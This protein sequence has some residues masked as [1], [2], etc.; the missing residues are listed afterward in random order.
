[1]SDVKQT[2][3]HMLI[4]IMNVAASPR[5]SC[6]LR[7]DMETLESEWVEVGIDRLLASGLGIFDDGRYVYHV[8]IANDPGF[9]TYLVVLERH[10]LEVMNVQP[11]PEVTDAHS[12]VRLGEDLCVASTGTDEIAAYRLDGCRVRDP[13]VLW[14]PTASGT[15]THHVNSL[16]VLG[17][18]LWCSAFGPRESERY[19]WATAANGYIRNVTQGSTLIDGL[20]QPHTVVWHDGHVYYC[21]SPLGTVNVDGDVFAYLHGYARGLVFA[22][23]GHL[24]VGTSLGRRPARAPDRAD[25]FDNLHDEGSPHGRCAVVRFSPSGSRTEIGLSHRGDEIYD[26]LIL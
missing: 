24:Y 21:N 13:R 14:A 8:C 2:G 20:R 6:L 16:F 26:L 11:L 18:D 22:P 4:S 17:D 5:P 25:V 23:D 7:L 10:S 3:Q 15:D 12:V 9:P 1:M 19:S